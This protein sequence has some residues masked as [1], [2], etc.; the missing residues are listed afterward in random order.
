[1]SRTGNDL[2][3]SPTKP[4][5]L[6][7]TMAGRITAWSPGMERRYGHKDR[8]A[9]GQSAH[10]LLRTTFPRAL[11]DIEK[12]LLS[13][14]VW[15]GGVIH[16]HADGDPVMAVNHWTLC[17]DGASETWLVTEAHSNIGPGDAGMNQCVADI[18]ELAAHALSEPLTAIAN[19]VDGT[20]RILQAGWPDLGLARVAVRR[21]L[22]Q[23]GRGR[24][25]I[26]LLRA[27]AGVLRD[28]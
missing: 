4:D 21:A 11:P 8:E 12:V 18:I 2:G 15:T 14:N 10:R 22:D 6:V 5:T 7:R 23:T 1:M 25:G 24:D 27:L 26:C 28:R 19:Y 13:R 20:G 9:L 3:L 17:R 16:R